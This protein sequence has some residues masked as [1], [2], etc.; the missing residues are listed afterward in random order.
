LIVDFSPGGSCNIVDESSTWL[1]NKGT[2]FTHS[3]HQ[4]CALHA[5]R[6]NT[7]FQVTGGTGAF[8][9]AIGSGQEFSPAPSSSNAKPPVIYNGTISF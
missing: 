4:D 6:I 1:F 5:L 7:T 2:I 8:Q 3:Y 9:G